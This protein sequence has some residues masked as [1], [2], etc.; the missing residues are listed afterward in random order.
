MPVWLEKL[1][2]KA[3]LTFS[4]TQG[5]ERAIRAHT[6]FPYNRFRFVGKLTFGI[7]GVYPARQSLAD[8]NNALGRMPFFALSTGQELV[9]FLCPDVMLRGRPFSFARF[10]SLAVVPSERLDVIDVRKG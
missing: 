2:A 9:R 10:E 6:Q 3:I 1:V 8:E 4:Y 5:A 7:R